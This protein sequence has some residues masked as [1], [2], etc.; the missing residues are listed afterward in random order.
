MRL[1]KKSVALIAV[2]AAGV[3]FMILFLKERQTQVVYLIGVV[4]F[5]AWLLSEGLS[6]EGG[7]D[8]IVAV[9]AVLGPAVVHFL[10]K[11]P[12]VQV[13]NGWVNTAGQFL[14]FDMLGIQGICSVDKETTIVVC[15]FL[16]FTVVKLVNG[17]ATAMARQ[18]GPSAPEFKERNFTEKSRAFCCV[19]KQ[20]LQSIDRETAWNESL[21]TSMD[22]EVERFVRG[23][24][25]KRF[26]DLLTCLKNTRNK[27]A[28][29][30]VLGDPG[31]GKS[32]A[33]RKLCQDLLDESARTKKIPVYVN[34]KK[35]NQNWSMNRLPERRDLIAFIKETLYEGGDISTDTFLDAYFDK[36]LEEG[37]WYFVFDSFDEMPCLMGRQN[38]Q[39]LI[40]KISELL[41]Q[42]MTGANQSGGI[43][44]SRLY[45]SPSEALGATITMKIQRFNDIKIKT[46]LQKYL[47]NVGEVIPKLF[48]EREDLV[49][50]CRNPFYLALLA[51]YLQNNGIR[52]PQNQM[53]LYLSFV[54][55]RLH[56]C[57]EKLEAEHFTE[58]AIHESAKALAVFMQNS[59]E[60][61]LECPLCALR[62]YGQVTDWRKALRLLEYAKICRF[63]GENE[64]VSFVHRRFQEFFLV[65]SIIEQE[66]GIQRAD[67]ESI[68]SGSG[69]RDAL[70]LYCE[71]A[72]EEKAREIANFCWE[73]IQRYIGKSKSVWN[74]GGVELISALHFMAEA[75]RNRQCIIRGFQGKLEWLVKKHLN[76][77]TDFVVQMA[78]VDVMVLFRQR[79][80]Q[81]LVQKVFTLNNRLLCDMVVENC[82]VI[83]QLNSQV[84]S[85]F[86]S[87]ILQMN[88]RTF[89]E[90]FWNMRFSLSISKGFR[91]IRFVHLALA[92][93]EVM[94]LL[95]FTASAAAAVALGVGV[96]TNN[97]VVLKIM[98]AQ[99]SF[100]YRETDVSQ[101]VYLF[102]P[103]TLTMEF[104]MISNR[105]NIRRAAYYEPNIKEKLNTFQPFALHGASVLL[106]FSLLPMAIFII[107]ELSGVEWMR[108][109]WVLVAAPCLLAF[110]VLFLPIILHD[111]SA[112]LKKVKWKQIRK[113][114]AKVLMSWK[115]YLALF[116]GL[117]VVAGASLLVWLLV[118]FLFRHIILLCLLFFV[119]GAALLTWA[120]FLAAHRIKDGCWFRKQPSVRTIT[121]EALAVNLEKLYYTKSKLRYVNFLLEEKVELTGRW[122]NNERPKYDYDELNYSLAKLDSVH[123][124]SCSYLF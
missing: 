13:L 120:G 58:E 111:V 71:V 62:G 91:Y 39:E 2:L 64:T 101:F 51:N 118:K 57:A 44:A 9:G 65:E 78:L 8:V 26:S 27:N 122:D 110:A 53:E 93:F 95:L 84:E 12:P 102:L 74:E 54:Q 5:A 15:F 28:I 55:Y 94:F 116:A 96:I 69:L 37:R 72:E 107:V 17:R 18:K 73:T 89:W 10:A 85:K 16:L 47:N 19:L 68:I 14:L 82:R 83:R 3:L 92:V 23:K 46:M 34:L 112:S 24:R 80:L 48:G 29:F 1:T 115:T 77:S 90:R 60:Y 59:T 121:R 49:V 11:A 114:I 103:W 56:R 25:K 45:K 104:A 105:H 81:K 35:W 63:G 119:M 79:Q 50:L 100:S 40:N 98:P 86:V 52:F 43:I 21:F 61:G 87:Y 109:V 124:N 32:V 36:M 66:Q 4:A 108:L 117:A 22:A 97:P 76:H 123:L 99:G 33:L 88:I 42:F 106:Y 31:A 6:I 75:F 67:Y 7:S 113:K 70:V 20:R 41:C 30:L 38:C